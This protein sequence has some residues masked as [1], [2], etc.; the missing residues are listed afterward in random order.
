M[1]ARPAGG[2]F[3]LYRSRLSGLHRSRQEARERKLRRE[4]REPDGLPLR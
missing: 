4:A 2:R 3:Q 1:T